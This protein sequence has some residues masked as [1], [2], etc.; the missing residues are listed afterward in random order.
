MLHLSI[1]IAKELSILVNISYLSV[2]I[3]NAVGFS[4]ALDEERGLAFKQFVE[5]SHLISVDVHLQS[6]H[7][8]VLPFR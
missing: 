1:P 8:F 2:V 6:Q 7:V 3:L 4:I 5:S